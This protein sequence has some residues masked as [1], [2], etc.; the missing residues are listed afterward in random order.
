MTLANREPPSLQRLDGAAFQQLAEIPAEVEWF[1]NLRNPNTRKAYQA[2]LRD[3]TAY[4]GI[5]QPEDFRRIT[6]A[7]VIA[8]R[9]HLVSRELGASTI[10][11]KL[12]ALS[13]LYAYLCDRNAVESN[14]VAGVSQAHQRHDRGGRHPR[15]QRRPGQ[16]A[17]RGAG[18]RAP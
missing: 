12:A 15:H 10:R 17:A 2:D 4:T 1:A 7:H 16:S 6:R 11:R 14:P 18:S 9:D 5:Q 8:W 3:F 13:S